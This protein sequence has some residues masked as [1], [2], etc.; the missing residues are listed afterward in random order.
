[1]ISRAARGLL[2][3]GLVVFLAT[4][5]AEAENTCRHPR[6]VALSG[7]WAE[8]LGALH[9]TACAEVP[10]H[11]LADQLG[12]GL[13]R[14]E[15]LDGLWQA[16]RWYPY[17]LAPV[18]IG[19]LLLAWARP[20]ARR[21]IGVSLLVLAVLLAGFEA[22]YL[23]FE[24]VP[25]IARL[26]RAEVVLAWLCVV[27]VLFV[28]RRDDRRIDAVEAHVAA[29]ALLGALHLVTLP[30]S[31]GRVWWRDYPAAD[32]F[33]AVTQN[34]RPGF[35]VGLAALLLAAAA[36]YLRRGAEVAE[37]VPGSVTASTSP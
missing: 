22:V 16:R 1:V 12:A 14:G 36:V 19:A 28:R 18:W 7:T 33:A 26:G 32:V 35:W 15:L 3:A 34:F 17:A 24:Y 13:A 21:G 6:L 27:A 9:G 10:A 37:P 23:G 25:M 20:G 30:T 29:Q 5:F 31:Q 8:P 11:V 2:L 4:A